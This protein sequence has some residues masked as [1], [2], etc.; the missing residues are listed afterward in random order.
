MSGIT[1]C[2]RTYLAWRDALLPPRSARKRWVVVGLLAAVIYPLAALAIWLI[3]LPSTERIVSNPLNQELNG[4]TISREEIPFLL[5]HVREESG[6]WPEEA[7]WNLQ[8]RSERS[9]VFT[10][11]YSSFGGLVER[12]HIV[13]IRN[14]GPYQLAVSTTVLRSL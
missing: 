8:S 13:S 4:L 6:L 14:H 5:S 7:V 2:Y 1:S 10:M 12:R 11:D 3:V 9:L